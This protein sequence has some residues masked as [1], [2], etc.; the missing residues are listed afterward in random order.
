MKRFT[1]EDLDRTVEGGIIASCQPVAGGPLDQDEIVV[2]MALACEKGGAK[3][4][5]IEGVERVA[6]V[7]RASRIP[8]IGI[9][10]RDLENTDVRI[11]PGIDEVRGL[12]D[13][14]ADIIAFDATHRSRPVRRE[15]IAEAILASGCHAMADCAS[16]RDVHFALA[17]DVGFIG[18]TLSGYVGGNTPVE[19][20]YD[21]LSSAVE[22]APR[23]IAEGRYNTPDRARQACRL[24]AWGVTVGTALTRIET[25]TGWFAEGLESLSG[26]A[27]RVLVMRRR[28]SV[29][30]AGGSASAGRRDSGA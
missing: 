18:T 23:V 24:G 17:C 22:I 16:I 1:I 5:R 15:K 11:T 21:F 3:A 25:M 6:K 29:A 28:L 8:V 4:L 10:K 12:A 20:D 26:E 7:R 2:A 19:P 14:G 27:G 9:V 30:P 13:A